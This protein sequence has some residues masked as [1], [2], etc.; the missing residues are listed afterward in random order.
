MGLETN[1]DYLMEVLM[2]TACEGACVGILAIWLIQ[3]YLIVQHCPDMIILHYTP[4]RIMLNMC[5]TFVYHHTFT[6]HVTDFI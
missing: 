3:L 2:P 4:R 1:Y 6:C 5:K